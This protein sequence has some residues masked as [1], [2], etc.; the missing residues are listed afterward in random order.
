MDKYTISNHY[1]TIP[2]HEKQNNLAPLGFGLNNPMSYI[3]FGH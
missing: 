3:T 1:L 2:T